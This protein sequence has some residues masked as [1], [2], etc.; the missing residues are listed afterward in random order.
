MSA[1]EK[2]WKVGRAMDKLEENKQEHIEYIIKVTEICKMALHDNTPRLRKLLNNMSYE[3]VTD[4]SE[5]CE[6]IYET[7]LGNQKVEKFLKEAKELG[8]EEAKKKWGIDTP[9]ENL[10]TVAYKKAQEEEIKSDI[11]KPT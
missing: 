4:I 11:I 9:S 6:E 10:S 5:T 3:Q 2:Q 7:Y 1:Y 8:L